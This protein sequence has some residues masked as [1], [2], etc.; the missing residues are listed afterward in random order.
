MKLFD[1]LNFRNH[2]E[3]AGEGEPCVQTSTGEVHLRISRRGAVRPDENL[4]GGNPCLQT[5]LLHHQRQH[6]KDEQGKV[7]SCQRYQMKL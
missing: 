5:K 4:L 7:R 6:Q 3:G 2:T 1:R